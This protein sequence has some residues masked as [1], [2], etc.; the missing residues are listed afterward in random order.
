MPKNLAEGT[1]IY[2]R[3]K[4]ESGV[5]FPIEMTVQLMTPKK[6]KKH[7]Y[8]IRMSDYKVDAFDP[9]EI[10]PFPGLKEYGD[11]KPLTQN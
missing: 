2:E 11:S 8:Q 6:K 3:K 7:V 10:K 1:V 5:Y 4:H 9:S